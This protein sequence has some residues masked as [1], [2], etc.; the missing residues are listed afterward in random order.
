MRENIWVYRRINLVVDLG[1]TGLAFILAGW[2]RMEFDIWFPTPYQVDYQ[3]L[4]L[5]LPIW[6]FFLAINQRL[7]EYRMVGFEET[8]KNLS[9]TLLKCLG[10]LLGILFLSR[11]LD[12]SRAT[13]I[14]FAV[15]N[16]LLLLGFRKI[17]AS[18]LAFYRKRGHNQQRILLVGSGQM[19]REF[20]RKSKSH[21]EWGWQIAGILEWDYSKIGTRV[22]GVMVTY[23][24]NQ[25]SQLIQNDHVDYVVYAVPRRF[26]HGL[27]E[28]INLC[29]EMG[30]KIYL[31]ADFFNLKLARKQFRFLF[32]QPAL[33]YSTGPSRDGSLFLK[34]ALD[35]LMAFLI[36]LLASPLML[37]AAVLVKL[38]STGPVFFKQ[39]RTGLNGKKFT[40]YKFRTMVQGAE[41]LKS[42]LL[43][44][45]EMSG[46]VFKMA[47]DPRLTKIGKLLRKTSIDELPQ[48]FNVI[49]GDMSL[50]GPRPPL[51]EEVAQ[52]DHWQRRKLSIKPGLTCLWQVNGRNKI[53][54]ENWMKL[55]LHYIDN[56]SLWLDAKILLKTVP[57]VL[58]GLGAK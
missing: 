11:R 4:F 16:L 58:A 2:A 53:D 39:T 34:Y 15:F 44:Q 29:E 7:Y 36:L 54:F 23:S 47:A 38:S 20:I 50:V 41:E 28:S 45:N 46:P 27:E 17:L 18:A 42:A 49:K 52:Y 5:I 8:F 32:N 19:A 35:K 1:L 48:L 26:L 55:D 6:G 43:S 51:P 24:L 14:L 3:L 56:W 25:L 33:F 30:V 21:P 12:P 40:L 22:E 31:L 13:L 10:I 57:A 37:V 9:L